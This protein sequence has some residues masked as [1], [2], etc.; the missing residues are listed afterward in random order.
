MLV[1]LEDLTFS[2]GDRIIFENV[3]LSIDEKDRIGLI[4]INGVGKSTF[5]NV[6]LGF[7]T[8]YDG[9]VR[10]KNGL[11]IGYLRQNGALDSTNTVYEEMKSVFKPLLDTEAKMRQLEVEM[12]SIPNDSNEYKSCVSE[13]ARLSNI[14]ETADGYNIDVKIKMVLSGMGFGADLD[15]DI[16]VMSGGEKTRLALAK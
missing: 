5:L 11:R 13:Y 4:G 9:V 10:M 6:L 14:F 12:S 1:N 16:S 15:K 7:L 8:D 2:Y 3:N